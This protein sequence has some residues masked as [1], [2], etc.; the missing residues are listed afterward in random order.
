[1]R[2]SRLFLGTVLILGAG[3]RPIAAQAPA[4]STSDAP[5]VLSVARQAVQAADFHAIGHL[6]RVD[7]TG[8][9][10]TYGISIK[11]RWFPGVLRV[12]V[13]TTPPASEGPKARSHILLEMRPDG[14][15]SIQIAHPGDTTPS[16]LPFDKWGDGPL[17]PGFSYE[18]FMEEQYFWPVQAPLEKT[19]FGARDCD[20]LKSTPGA[21]DR[22]HY[23][24]VKS[25]LDHSIAFPVYVEKSLK[26]AGT[27]KEFTYS[28]LRHDGGVWSAH[29]VEEKTHGTAGSELLIID[30]GTAK[31]NLALRDFSSEQLVRF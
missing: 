19:R 9:R 28:G 6:V 15:N 14:R 20:L 30:R 11:A 17:G 23:A 22:T 1:V 7:A 5:N 24:G 13:E 16:A 29:Q 4:T 18:D 26:G 8:A 10:T 2:F 3:G 25:W 27:L 31:A 21:A 12:L